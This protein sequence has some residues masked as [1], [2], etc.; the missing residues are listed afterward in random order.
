MTRCHQAFCRG[1]R[2]LRKGATPF[3]GSRVNRLTSQIDGLRCLDG[4]LWLW[5]DIPER[6]R[7]ARR[8]GTRPILVWCHITSLARPFNQPSHHR[9]DRSDCGHERTPRSRLL[10]SRPPE[11]PAPEVDAARDER[12][13]AKASRSGR[14]HQARLSAARRLYLRRRALAAP[15]RSDPPGRLR[16]RPRK[17]WPR[18]RRRR[19]ARRGRA[20]VPASTPAVGPIECLPPG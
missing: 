20:A 7:R 18:R 2:T 13:G 5:R 10:K 19:C 9:L 11:V 1:S 8:N 14:L 17:R 12:G 4:S 3:A 6:S 16:R 15:S